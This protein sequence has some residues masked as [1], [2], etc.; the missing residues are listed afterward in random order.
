MQQIPITVIGATGYTGLELVRLLINHPKAEIVSVTS[1]QFAGESLSDVF[2]AFKGKTDLICE[3]LQVSSIAKKIKVAFLCL[4]HGESMSIAKSFRQH[5][6][7]VIDL[8][9]DFRIKNVGVYESFYQKH[10]QKEL[11]KT[12]V[13]GMPELYRNQIKQASLIACP[14]CYPTSIILALAPMLEKRMILTQG[15][16]CDSKSG[17][18]GAGRSAALSNHFCEVHDDFKAYKISG[19]RH[20]PEIEQELSNLAGEPLNI[21]FTPH[22]V[23]IDRGIFSTIYCKPVRKWPLEKIIQL[24]QKFYR[25]E[26]FV[27]VGNAGFIP[28]TKNVRGTNFCHI[29]VHLNEQTETLIICSVIDNLT[30]GASG[31]AVQC[32]NLMSGFNETMG[33]IQI[34]LVP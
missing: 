8:S 24:Y 28:S 19:H 6:V 13:Y 25:K 1:R 16:I 22:L 2:P 17:V 21:V 14:G 20:V 27:Y 3:K 12:A 15:I 23:P 5:G 11:L 4:P 31:Q 10:T 7:K 32:F 33:L 34:G 18:S 29:G 9:A 30:K 26:K